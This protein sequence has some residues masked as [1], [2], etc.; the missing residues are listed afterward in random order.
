MTAEKKKTS[1]GVFL[2]QIHDRL[3]RVY[4]DCICPL[5]HDSAFQ[6]LIAVMLS[7]QCRDDRVNMVTRQLFAAAPDA[8]RMAALSVETIAEIIQPCGLHQVKSKNVKAAA[9][10]ILE[11]FSGKVPE[12]MEDL[13]QLPGIGR[14][15]ANV[16][17]GNAFGIPGFPVDTH[18]RRV[19]N[20]LGAVATA[21]PEKIEHRVNALIEPEVWTN[22]SHLVIQ[23]GRKVCHAG[24][25]CC[26][27][28]VLNEI[29]P[30]KGVK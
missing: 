11:R 9:E 10:M 8:E 15:S 18:V 6:L 3:Y 27:D 26:A 4:G 22:F 24:K 28:C 13:I 7:A 12:N 21:D 1:A 19:L 17:L 2:R 20:R 23:H 14:K 5:E 25:A 29:C 30:K 16:I